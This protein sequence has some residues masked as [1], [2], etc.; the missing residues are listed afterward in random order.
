[1]V[2]ILH[3]SI[4]YLKYISFLIYLFK[5]GGF[6]INLTSNLEFKLIKEG[7][8]KLWTIK[9]ELMENLSKAGPGKYNEPVFFNPGMEFSRDLSILII[10]QFLT[11][12]QMKSNSNPRIKILDGLAGIGAR[13][14]RIGN[15]TS[16][17]KELGA[18]IFINDNNP[19]A[20]KL[21]EKNILE[22]DISNAIPSKND[23]N[24]LLAE[25]RF[26]YIDIDPFG[27]PIKFLDS[28]SRML[29]HQGILA[30]TATDTAPLFGTYPKTCARRYDAQSCRTPFSHELGTRIL[31]GACVRI[32]A[33]HNLGLVP[34]LTHATDYYYRVY[35]RGLKSRNFANQSIEQLGFIIQQEKSNEY[36]IIEQ[37]TFY[38]NNPG[39]EFNK[40]YKIAGPL[41]IGRLFDSLFVKN[42]KI[43]TH[44]FGTEKQILKLQPLWLEEADLPPGFYDSNLLASEL[45]ITT[46]PLNNILNT[47]R[48]SDYLCS[49]THFN[50]NAF[51][52]NMNFHE[53]CKLLRNVG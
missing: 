44:H 17:L 28:A 35:L 31:I 5:F 6:V 51:K 23:L 38:S 13:G 2:L 19:L 26:D 42:L 52:T 36:K 22:N 3:L 9:S 8:T 11:E 41:W 32:A 4:L 18:K 1:M 33:K 49:K 45:K 20:H 14:V 47:L 46:P 7:N 10:E 21:I 25:E 39:I 16:I 12:K 48:N 30:V 50:S 15:E 40:P 29:R 37:S 24:L 43:G 27:S 34:I 53:L